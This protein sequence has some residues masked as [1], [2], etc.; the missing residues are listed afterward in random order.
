MEFF[1]AARINVETRGFD[2]G[3]E[4][5]GQ[6]RC[7]LSDKQASPASTYS[8][9]FQDDFLEMKKSD[10]EDA[11]L[12][13]SNLVSRLTNQWLCK[14][15]PK[16]LLFER[17]L[18]L[19]KTLINTKIDMDNRAQMVDWMFEVLHS[20]QHTFNI[21]TYFRSVTLMDFYLKQTQSRPKNTDL[22][23]IGVTCMYIASKYE[24]IYPL[25]IKRFLKYA[26]ANR[27]TY[28]Q[29]RDCEILI[30]Q[31]VGFYVSFKTPEEVLHHFIFMIFGQS[32]ETAV[33]VAKAKAF[34][35]YSLF[36]V[37]FN[38]YE[39]RFLAFSCIF[40]AVNY[41]VEWASSEAGAKVHEF[42]RRK[43][44]VVKAFLNSEMA[45]DRIPVEIHMLID[46]EK[47]YL[48]RVN[49]KLNLCAQFEEFT[50]FNDNFIV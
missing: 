18:D 17:T 22:H 3:K 29:I 23:I 39:I 21:H 16:D 40:I 50:E 47:K 9:T 34:L 33:L 4:R 12:E 2:S 19:Q 28:E 43:R 13:P 24:D 35:L 11:E 8:K 49:K 44:A 36:N 10:V 20:L 7:H 1:D 5:F 42:W 26:C 32:A 30:L 6:Q 45:E 41:L 31:T 14:Y 48:K 15:S 37:R 46:S 25:P 27:F 38:D